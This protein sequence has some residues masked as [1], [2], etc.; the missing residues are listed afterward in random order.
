MIKVVFH[1]GGTFWGGRGWK[2]HVW[3]VSKFVL[4]FQPFMLFL[5]VNIEEYKCDIIY[6]RCSCRLFYLQLHSVLKSTQQNYRKLHK[7]LF[8]L[9]SN[10]VGV[11]FTW[12]QIRKAL[13]SERETCHG[14]PGDFRIQDQNTKWNF[15]PIPAAI[16][17]EISLKNI[18]K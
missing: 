7:K 5:C 2:H 10:M 17:H 11:K 15:T 9:N 12:L 16:N 6:N 14:G 8:V 4:S 13:V 1:E 18:T 3:V